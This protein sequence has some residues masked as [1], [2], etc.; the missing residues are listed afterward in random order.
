M[1]TW[2]GR[3]P[4]QRPPCPALSPPPAAL[5]FAVLLLLQDAPPSHPVKAHGPRGSPLLRQGKGTASRLPALPQRFLR[6]SFPSD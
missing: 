6:R 5:H 4:G 2:R 1:G 3:G